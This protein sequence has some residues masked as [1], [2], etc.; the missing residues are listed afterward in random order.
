MISDYLHG[1]IDNR[2]EKS[3]TKNI[4][5]YTGLILSKGNHLEPIFP[6]E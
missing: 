3:D 2:K 4:I 6:K 5:T 1:I